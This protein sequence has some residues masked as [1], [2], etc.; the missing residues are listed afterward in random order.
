MMK[1]V[2][3]NSVIENKTTNNIMIA[4][5]AC[6]VFSLV[7]TIIDI[8][9]RFPLQSEYIDYSDIELTVINVLGL[10]IQAVFFAYGFVHTLRGSLLPK[11]M[12]IVTAAMCITGSTHIPEDAT[13]QILALIIFLIIPSTIGA[14]ASILFFICR[15]NY[16]LL[17]V[18]VYL[19]SIFEIGRIVLSMITTAC[20]AGQYFTMNNTIGMLLKIFIYALIIYQT[21]VLCKKRANAVA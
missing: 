14:A 6:V 8:I 18:L 21:N 3:R 16:M 20:Y 9:I 7:A 15:K 11:R 17:P 2:E 4:L 13:W 10:V 1:V 12:G 19:S 5:Y